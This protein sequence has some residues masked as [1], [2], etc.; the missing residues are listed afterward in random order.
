MITDNS[1][2]IWF[3]LPPG[4]RHQATLLTSGPGELFK[5]ALQAA[6]AM[7]DQNQGPE[8]IIIFQHFVAGDVQNS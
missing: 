5:A 3:A 4:L 2:S 8:L 7:A 6:V 1:H